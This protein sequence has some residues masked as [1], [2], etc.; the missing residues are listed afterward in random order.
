MLLPDFSSGPH[1][2]FTYQGWD[3][4]TVR[5]GK[6]LWDVLHVGRRSLTL[7]VKPSHK[8]IPGRRRRLSNVISIIL[9]RVQCCR[10]EPTVCKSNQVNKPE[11]GDV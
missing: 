7:A 6:N 4:E 2:C 9:L 10:T 11:L 8:C 5:Q 1:G 3:L